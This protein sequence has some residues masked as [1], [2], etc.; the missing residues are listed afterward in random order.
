MESYTSNLF[1]Y[2]V[3][4]IGCIFY[5]RNSTIKPAL[6]IGL[7]IALMI[8]GKME[9]NRRQQPNK[10][11]S[12]KPKVKENEIKQDVID[13]L[14]SIQDIYRY[15]PQA[16][17][18]VVDGIKNFTRLYDSTVITP[19]NSNLTFDMMR[20]TQSNIIESLKS[21]GISLPSDPNLIAK[22]KRVITILSELLDQYLGHIL[23]I[24]K[25]HLHDTGYTVDY[26]PIIL[27]PQPA[28]YYNT[29]LGEYY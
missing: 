28:N 22:H 7:S 8:I 24:H 10:I 26:K 14:Y 13:V 25:K 1:I 2:V 4:I 16:Y 3:I 5:Y 20:R 19:K 11:D 27:G 29:L 9:Y 15:N 6:V 12:I 23:Y 21:I 17:E 18:D